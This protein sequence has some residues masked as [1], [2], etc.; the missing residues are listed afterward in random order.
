MK[1]NK[2]LSDHLLF[3]FRNQFMLLDN[4]DLFHQTLFNAV[5][6]MYAYLFDEKTFNAFQKACSP[7]LKH[8]EEKWTKKLEKSKKPSRTTVVRKRKSSEISKEK[9][10]KETKS[11]RSVRKNSSAGRR[12]SERKS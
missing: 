3:D 1:I 7:Q 8:M 5:A 10:V 12:K 11:V 4:P 2:K 9:I 6:Y